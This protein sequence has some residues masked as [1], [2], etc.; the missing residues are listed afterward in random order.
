MAAHPARPTI[1]EKG[2]RGTTALGSRNTLLSI[3][4][5]DQESWGNKYPILFYSWPLR[6]ASFCHWPDLTVCKRARE[7]FGAV[8]LLGGQQAGQRR[9][10]ECGAYP[11]SL[12]APRQ[13]R[14][15]CRF[16]GFP[17]RAGTTSVEEEEGC[18]VDRRLGI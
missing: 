12:M 8:R 9:M 7:T 10:E 5:S 18:G 14:C 3:L 13:S 2:Q 6:L 17:L 16:R 11:H 4:E 1:V 15:I